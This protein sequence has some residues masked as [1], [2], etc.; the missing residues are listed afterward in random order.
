[1]PARRA[2]SRWFA[3][4]AWHS[5]AE[6]FASIQPKVELATSTITVSRRLGHAARQDGSSVPAGDVITGVN[7]RA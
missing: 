3:T 6:E 1:M 4:C 7:R 5:T 2:A